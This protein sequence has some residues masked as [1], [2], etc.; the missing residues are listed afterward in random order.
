VLAAVFKET[1]NRMLSGYLF[2]IR[3]LKDGGRCGIVVPHS[4]CG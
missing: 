4:V 1:N 3:Q 2:V